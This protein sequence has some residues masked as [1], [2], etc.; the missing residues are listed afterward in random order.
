MGVGPEKSSHLPNPSR[1]EEIASLESEI[2]SL[3]YR[4]YGLTDEEIAVVETK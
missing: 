2:D 3:V 4:L 1:E